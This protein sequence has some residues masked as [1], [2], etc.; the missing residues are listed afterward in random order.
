MPTGPKENTFHDFWRMVYQENV[1]TIVM[2]TAL[3]EHKRVTILLLYIFGIRI[4]RK[5]FNSRVLTILFLLKK[6]CDQYWPNHSR[7]FGDILVTLCD[8]ENFADIVIRQFELK[9][10]GVRNFFL[11]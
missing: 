5:Y 9:K 4:L 2:L 6:K 11:L 8:T 1:A 10:I 7:L 3:T